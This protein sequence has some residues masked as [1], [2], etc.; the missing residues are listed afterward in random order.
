MSAKHLSHNPHPI[1]LSE[2]NLE[3]ELISEFLRARGYK[4][5]DLAR[6]EEDERKS[7]MKE[8]CSYAG[9]ILADIEA[10]SRFRQK[11]KTLFGGI[12]V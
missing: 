7:L 12:H 6:L 3:M 4:F 9:V 11:L 1:E 2:A 10:K 5:S 8:A